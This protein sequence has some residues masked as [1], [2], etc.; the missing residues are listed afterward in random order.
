VPKTVKRQ[1]R[2]YSAM[3]KMIIFSVF[4]LICLSMA[5]ATWAQAP[6]FPVIKGLKPINMKGC[7]DITANGFYI[8]WPGASIGRLQVEAGVGYVNI[9]EQHGETFS[10]T[11]YRYDTTNTTPFTDLVTIPVYGTVTGSTFSLYSTDPEEPTRK[12]TD[13]YRYWTGT[14]QAD[15][16]LFGMGFTSR[17][18]PPIYWQNQSFNVRL[19]PSNGCPSLP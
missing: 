3:K 16:S 6:P 10:G 15:G 7:W 19:I 17:L 14:L 8:N 5:P 4:V 11:L 9:T 12:S 13:E 1:E 2:R 18:F